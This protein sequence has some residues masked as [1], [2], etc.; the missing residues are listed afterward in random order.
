V[1]SLGS[2]RNLFEVSRYTNEEASRRIENL[3]DILGCLDDHHP[4]HNVVV[5]GLNATDVRAEIEAEGFQISELRPDGFV[6]L[7]DAGVRDRIIG[8]A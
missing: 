5:H 3:L 8:R 1:W 2:E 7:Q 4:H 6:V